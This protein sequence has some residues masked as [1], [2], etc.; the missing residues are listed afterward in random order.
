MI[1]LIVPLR[2]WPADRIEAC[3]ASFSAVDTAILD[4]IVVVDF[5]SVERF[6]L[7]TLS[8]RVRVIRVEAAVWSLAEA[9]NVGAMSARNEILAKTDAD[10][11]LAPDSVGQFEARVR[12]MVEKAEFGLSLTPAIDLPPGLGPDEALAKLR[13][14]ENVG[15]SLR[16]R[17]G[18]GGLP[19]FRRAD[20]EEIGG[21]DSRLTGWGNED[22]DFSERLRR[23]G[24]RVSW[25]LPGAINIY[26]VAHPPKHLMPKV[27][28]LRRKNQ[29]LMAADKSVLRPLAFRHSKGLDLAAPALI[30]RVRP[31]VTLAVATRARPGRDRM[32]AEALAAFRK[33]A[34]DDY[35]V[36]VV[37]NG[38]TDEEFASLSKKLK[39]VRAIPNLRIERSPVASI[40]AS[41]NIITDLARGRYICVVDDDDI[42]LP[43]RLDDHL[44]A[45][46]KDGT[47]HGS[48]GGWIDFDED[49]GQIER[50][51][52]R[53]RRLPT[54]L[55]GRGKITAHPASLYRADVLRAVR[56]DESIM[57]GSDMDLALRMAA[58][59][60]RILHTGSFVTLRRYHA[61]NVTLTGTDEQ[62]VGG[63]RA[64]DRLWASFSR[65]HVAHLQESGAAGDP[66][67]VCRN[68]LTIEEIA[69]LV[70]AYVGQWRLI[71]PLEALTGGKQDIDPE[72]VEKLVELFG[73]E[74]TTRRPG[75]DQPVVYASDAIKGAGRALK[76]AAT[77]ETLMGKRPSLIA[78]A[79]LAAD[80]ALPVDLRPLLT[81][82]G[83]VLLRSARL[84]SAEDLLEV[85]SKIDA[86]SL[87]R[88]GL[89]TVAESDENGPY[90]Y[91]ISGPH[92]GA[93][94]VQ[95]TMQALQRTTGLTFEYLGQAGSGNPLL[96]GDKVH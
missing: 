80:Q 47:A 22:N 67:E 73:G 71:L 16:P 28:A 1:S 8:P 64:R 53:E 3:V 26:H 12:E 78:S 93:E 13:A 31:H 61:A 37:D 74:F 82:G 55:L 24:H 49:T 94:V 76:A 52:G 40:P 60:M 85:L 58:M 83:Q 41:R 69:G 18:E 4:D 10:I 75:V 96:L 5:G 46:V 91:L 89:H 48:H 43:N 25:T 39:S 9:I 27:A 21:Y 90:Y 30:N 86:S 35:E 72:R 42:A 95:S 66:D 7:R 32:T 70:P 51:P 79:Q 23:A 6:E 17:W 34:S 20:F 88:A 56:Y 68:H 50:N 36:V 11:L 92:A 84:G 77:I 29:A 87:L 54:L 59:G 45:F 19:I 81:E 33:Q 65:R 62:A 57:L 63:S 38:S 44:A 2:D 15:G 14:G